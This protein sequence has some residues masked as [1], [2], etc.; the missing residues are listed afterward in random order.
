MRGLLLA[1]GLAASA[2]A[3]VTQKPYADVVEFPG[4]PAGPH[5]DGDAFVSFD[6]ARLG[7]NV[8]PAKGETKAVL[9]ALHGMNDYAHGFHALAPYL[10]EHGVTVYAIDQRG[11]GRSPNQ[12]VWPGEDLMIAD[13]AALEQAVR[14]AH[15]GALFAFAGESMGGAVAIRAA[16]EGRIHPDRL[17][18]IAPAVWGWKNMPQAYRV[19]LWVAAHTRPAQ[20]VTPPKNLKIVASDNIKVLRENWKDPL[21]LKKTRVDAVYGLVSL[22][23]R[24]SD[25]VTALPPNT[26][27]LYG[28]KDQII[29]AKATFKAVRQLPKTVRTI[30]YPQGYHMLTRD[31]QGAVVWSDILAFID[32]PDAP[33]PSGLGAIPKAKRPA[34]KGVRTAQGNP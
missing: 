10:A 5:F 18:L 13:A 29:P 31:L 4:K 9:A 34:A 6:G 26:L 32:D 20:I 25:S 8:W 21:F 2:C 1:L 30:Y 7:L 16:A 28:A 17:I 19:A 14:S 33:P 24:A 22:M 15:P 23:Q 3:P 12:G 27:Y 11:F